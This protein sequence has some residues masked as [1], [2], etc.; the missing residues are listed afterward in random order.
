MARHL[1]KTDATI[2]ITKPTEATLRL[3]D[4]DGL[5]LLVKP[6]VGALVAIGL[7]HRRQAQNPFHW[8]ISRH[9]AKSGAQP[10]GIARWLGI[11]NGRLG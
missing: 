11:L 10:P 3:N 7:Q 5:Y 4:G 1:I 2:R 6:N 8:R 9:R